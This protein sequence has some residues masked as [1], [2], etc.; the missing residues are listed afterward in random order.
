MRIQDRFATA[1]PMVG[2][3]NAFSPVTEPSGQRCV[4]VL[5]LV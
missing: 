3:T 1:Q 5:V 4:T 2:M